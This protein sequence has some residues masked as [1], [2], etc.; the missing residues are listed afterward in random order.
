MFP[1]WRAAGKLPKD[2]RAHPGAGGARQRNVVRL[3]S[4]FLAFSVILAA[5]APAVGDINFY[6]LRGL[7]PERILG[8]ARLRAGAAAV[9]PQARTSAVR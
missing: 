2:N 3:L 7:A 4:A 8:A 5:Q 1:I 6:G 9:W